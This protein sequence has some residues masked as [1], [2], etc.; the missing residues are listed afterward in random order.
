MWVEF[1]NIRLREIK[2]TKKENHKDEAKATE[3]G[4]QKKS[5][6]KDKRE[7]PASKK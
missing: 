4:S 7:E 1:K 6:D 2:E 3:N 5:S